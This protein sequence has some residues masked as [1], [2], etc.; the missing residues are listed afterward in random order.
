MRGDRRLADRLVRIGARAAY[1]PHGLVTQVFERA[2]E[3][4]GAFRFLEN[5]RV[6]ARDVSDVV[7]D[8]TARACPEDFFVAVDGSSLSLVERT[9]KRQLGGVGAWKDFGRGLHVQSALAIDTR[10]VPIGL[11]GQV[12]WARDIRAKRRK[13]HRAMEGETRFPVR[14]LQEMHARFEGKRPWYLFDRG[15]DVWPILKFV[16]DTNVLATVRAVGT[17]RV[18]DSDGRRRQLT[19]VLEA[20]P[21]FGTIQVDLAARQDRPT[22]SSTFELRACKVQVSLAVGR[23][24]RELVR[25]GAV[26]VEEQSPPKGCSP[27]KWLLFTTHS[28]ATREDVQRAA[29][30]YALRWRIEDF[31]RAWKDGVCRVERTQLRSREALIKWA[32]ILAAVA[33]RAARLTHLAREADA[34]TQPATSEFSDDEIEA[35]VVLRKPKG[36]AP[37]HQPSL[38][39]VVRWVADLGGYTGKSSGGPPGATVIGRGLAKVEVLVEALPTLRAR[40]GSD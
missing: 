14:L 12:W 27:I 2:A 22:G 26:L 7:F 20:A 17:R 16:A 9:A 35:I 11:C 4:E 38:A 25:L 39:Q 13:A 10:G 21:S 5:R 40:L 34:Q 19:E 24:R 15:Y 31:H 3:R 37:S 18:F 36:I 8:A 33:T 23:K 29:K 1:Q 28:I 6:P 32:T 30:T